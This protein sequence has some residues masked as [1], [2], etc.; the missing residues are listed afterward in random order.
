MSDVPFPVLVAAVF[1]F[2]SLTMVHLAMRHQDAQ[3]A[4]PER[5]A[6][7]AAHELQSVTCAHCQS[8]EMREFG[9]NDADDDRRIVTCASCR[10]A[11]FRYTRGAAPHA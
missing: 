7:L 4:L 8:T 3:L 10:K 1:L 6:Y 11:L 2:T 5:D 9:F